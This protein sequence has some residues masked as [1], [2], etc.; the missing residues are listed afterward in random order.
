MRQI[1]IIDVSY[2]RDEMLG[3]RLTMSEKQDAWGDG[4][5]SSQSDLTE[6]DLGGQWLLNMCSD[7]WQGEHWAFSSL[8]LRSDSHFKN[9]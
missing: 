9:T 1:E 2:L 4:R 7:T 5:V 6:L 8:D 3:L